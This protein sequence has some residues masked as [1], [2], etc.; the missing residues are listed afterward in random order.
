MKT[1]T[2]LAIGLIAL[3]IAYPAAS[4]FTGNSIENGINTHFALMK[5]QGIDVVYEFERGFFNSS[6]TYTVSLSSLEGLKFTGRSQIAHSPFAGGL[7][8]LAAFD[9]EYTFD[10]STGIV[11][12]SGEKTLKLHYVSGLTGNIHAAFPLP[13]FKLKLGAEDSISVSA[14]EVDTNFSMDMSQADTQYKIPTI[15][16]S[17][18]KDPGKTVMTLSDIQAEGSKKRLYEDSFL[19]AG[20]DKLTIAKLEIQGRRDEQSLQMQQVA[21][22]S[23]ISANGDFIDIWVR[24]RAE[25]LTADKKELG[26]ASYEQSFKHL[27]GRTL[28]A[29]IDEFMS[30]ARLM[31]DDGEPDTTALTILGLKLLEHDPAFKLDRLAFR[32]PEGESVLTF[33]VALK[34]FKS[35]DIKDFLAMLVK[36]D[37][38][39]EVSLPL[40]L[41]RSQ[42]NLNQWHADLVKKG[43][44]Q[45]DSDPLKVTLAFSKGKATVNGKP[46]N[47]FSSGFSLDPSDGG[48]ERRS[49]RNHDDDDDD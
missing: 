39:G 19:F 23:K 45:P 43:F 29:I 5:K 35:E 38:N 25:T 33:G 22:D 40:A 47:V 6:Y 27:H 9:D 4:W 48:H 17:S 2:K 32:T 28:S 26:P 12:I 1:P 18:D 36:L 11:E 8:T 15:V 24:L 42:D 13:A 34:D 10:D 20:T 37:I 3:A 49:R 31:K 7:L 46:F 30:A 14:M 21:F 16:L 41:V 44:V